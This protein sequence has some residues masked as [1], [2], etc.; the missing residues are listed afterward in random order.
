M[1]PWYVYMILTRCEKIYTGITTDLDARFQAHRA[2][3]EGKPSARGAKYFRG[4][5]PLRIIYSEQYENRADA[6]RRER[7]IKRF[8]AQQ[9]RDIS[10]LPH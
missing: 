7:V 4:K 9:K 2:V 1:K 3:F 10:R 8:S 5:E 6:T